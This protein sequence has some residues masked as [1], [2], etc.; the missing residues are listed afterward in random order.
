MI[1]ASNAPFTIASL[2]TG[3]G[4][5]LL[6]LKLI[7]KFDKTLFVVM[8]MSPQLNKNQSNVL[9]AIAI[10]SPAMSSLNEAGRSLIASVAQ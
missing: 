10:I 6:A 8:S 9:R 4:K 1:M 7:Q 3:A 5:S 2:P